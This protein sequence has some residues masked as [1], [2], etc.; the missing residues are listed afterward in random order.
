MGNDGCGKS[1]RL[2]RS[3]GGHGIVEKE[4]EMIRSISDISRVDHNTTVLVEKT[5]EKDWIS[6]IIGIH[7][8]LT[9]SP[10]AFLFH[11]LANFQ[12]E[13]DANN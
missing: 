11:K 3:N 12:L 10:F 1:G 2:N 5:G 8:S 6:E 9:S 13:V 7:T 4:K